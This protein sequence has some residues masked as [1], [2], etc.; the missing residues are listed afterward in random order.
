M[1]GTITVGE[2]LSDPTSSNKITIGTGTTLDLVSGAGSVT[3]PPEATAAASLT[4]ALPALDGSALTNMAAGGKVLQ[5]VQ[6]E[7][8]STAST[9]SN[10]FQ[11]IPLSVSIQPSATSS[12]IMVF[13]NIMVGTQLG[14]AYGGNVRILRDSTQI[15]MGDAAGSRTRSSGSGYSDTDTYQ[16]FRTV[17]TYLDEPNTTSTLVYKVQFQSGWT[18]SAQYINRSGANG[19]GQHNGRYTSTITVMEIGA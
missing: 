9:T 18:A 1:A 5:V 19:D 13:A 14:G 16:V 7:F 12:K 3:L 10:T 4:G 15:I 8:S 6:S 11:D 2:L 17:T